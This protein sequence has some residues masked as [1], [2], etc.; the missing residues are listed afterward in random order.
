M[1]KGRGGKHFFAILTQAKERES[2][3]LFLIT[4]RTHRF[5]YSLSFSNRQAIISLVVLL[6][7]IPAGPTL[8]SPSSFSTAEEIPSLSHLIERLT[9]PGGCKWWSR[10]A[11]SFSSSTLNLLITAPTELSIDLPPPQPPPL[12][13]LISSVSATTNA[14]VHSI[15]WRVFALAA[16]WRVFDNVKT[17]E[18]V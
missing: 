6:P 5:V 8:S 7:G 4:G 13:S 17:N 12:P 10:L 1:S 18:C 2:T 11:I 16:A 14:Q 3:P 15:F 9:L